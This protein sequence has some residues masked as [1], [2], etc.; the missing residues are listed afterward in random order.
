MNQITLTSTNGLETQKLEILERMFKQLPLKKLQE[1]EKTAGTVPEWD[2][3]N[4][5]THV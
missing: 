5:K 1:L 4:R 2:G 3:S